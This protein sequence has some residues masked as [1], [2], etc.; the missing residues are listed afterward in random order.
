MSISGVINTH[1]TVAYLIGQH[2]TDEQQDYF[3][4]R[5]A[6]GEIRG[7]LSMP[8]PV[9]Q[10]RRAPY[11]ERRDVGAFLGGAH[12]LPVKIA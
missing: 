1:F 2:G 8:E 11:R 10:S 12:N 3:L 4:P 9:W 6:T 7:A 5:M